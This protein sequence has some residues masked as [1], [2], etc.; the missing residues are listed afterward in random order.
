[1]TQHG[2]VHWETASAV[3][4][5]QELIIPPAVVETQTADN[6]VG[7]IIRGLRVDMGQIWGGSDLCCLTLSVDSVSAN[8]LACKYLNSVLPVHVFLM[9]T[10]CLQ[11]QTALV[12]SLLTVIMGFVGPLFC[13]VRK[14]QEATHLLA[15]ERTLE[16]ILDAEL[17]VNTTTAPDPSDVARTALLVAQCYAPDCGSASAEEEQS[18]RRLRRAEGEE[19]GVM[20][21]GNVNDAKPVHHC[22]PGCCANRATSVKRATAAIMTPL[23]RRLWTPALNRWLQVYPVVCVLL[24]LWSVH[25]LLPR[26]E[27]IIHGAAV[28]AMDRE[29]PAAADAAPGD[30]SAFRRESR[31]R[32]TK[33]IRFLSDSMARVR[34]LIW[35]CATTPVMAIHYTLFKRGSIYGR[36]ETG[37]SALMSF[38]RLRSALPMRVLSQLGSSLDLRAPGLYATWSLALHFFG[39]FAAW[40][41]AYLC[42]ADVAAHVLAGSLWRRFYVRLRTWPWRLAAVVDETLTMAERLAEAEAFWNAPECCLDEFFSIRFRNSLESVLD[43]STERIQRFLVAVFKYTLAATTHSEDAFAHMR[44]CL[45]ACCKPPSM[46]TVSARHVLSELRRAHGRWKKKAKKRGPTARATAHSR[47]VWTKTPKD[48]G[49]HSRRAH[50]MFMEWRKPQLKA[51]QPRP[52]WLP[53]ASYRNEIQ[54]KLFAEWRL[55]SLAD[56]KAWR[57]TA[58]KKTQAA[59]RRIDPLEE[60]IKSCADG[61]ERDLSS[62]PWGLG[63]AEFPVATEFVEAEVRDYVRTSQS[64]VRQYAQDWRTVSDG[65]VPPPGLVRGT[66]T[67][68]QPCGSRCDGCLRDLPPAEQNYESIVAALRVIVAP[69]CVVTHARLLIVHIS[70]AENPAGFAVRNVTHLKSP[71]FTGEFLRLDLCE[72]FLDAGG[73]LAPPFD[74][75]GRSV[76]L[77]GRGSPDLCTEIDVAREACRLCGGDEDLLRWQVLSYIPVV[78][79]TRVVYR[80][81]EASEVSVAQAVE[82]EEEVG[83]ATRAARMFDA[84]V[85]AAERAP[86]G[87]GDGGGG[88]GGGGDGGSDSGGGGGGRDGEPDYVHEWEAAWR[89]AR[90]RRRARQGPPPPAPPPDP[91]PAHG[92]IDPAPGPRRPVVDKRPRESKYPRL[93]HP[94]PYPGRFSEVRLVD[95]DALATY[96]MR[97]FCFHPDHGGTCSWNQQSRTAPLARLWAWLEA[98]DRYPTKA[99]HKGHVPS[100]AEEAVARGVVEAMPEARPWLDAELRHRPG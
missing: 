40:P 56:K 30:S 77:Y 62:M 45:N 39:P 100:A 72:P 91:A 11:H 58:R 87:G 49:R 27:R 47:P 93:L 44:K 22:R 13:T 12:L 6:M 59:R 57:A 89:A 7:N 53:P 5:T 31:T 83:A 76:Q 33:M 43:L 61:C 71:K 81:T 1:M 54:R 9:A 69:K 8:T 19:I 85:G 17:E 94:R 23:R 32:A 52:A 78:S 79:G 60:Y 67:M 15:L 66:L 18:S 96:D 2:M 38:C 37:E 98:A 36:E 35:V 82:D 34:L 29:D 73:C 4:R 42:E 92:P 48:R 95:N 25:N 28:R 64:F 20:F 86:R 75:A 26:A 70:T 80:V 41:L 88:G 21:S 16:R 10:Y 51:E 14:M 68:R 50:W 24:L 3:V 99:A 74:C 46:A 84:V 63:D 55:L 65:V 90:V 97:A